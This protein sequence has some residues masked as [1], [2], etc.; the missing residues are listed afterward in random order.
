MQFQGTEVS[1]LNGSISFTK[2]KSKEE[3]FTLWKVSPLL[4][5]L[6]MYQEGNS[7]KVGSIA[8]GKSKW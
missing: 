7:L 3:V 5:L 6:K 4:M 2:T 8:P 1:L